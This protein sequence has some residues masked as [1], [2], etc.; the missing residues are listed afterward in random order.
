MQVKIVCVGKLKEKYFV[1]GIKEYSKRI[2]A[3]T[4]FEI[5]EVKDEKDRDNFSPEDINKIKEIEGERILSKIK[6]DDYVITLE[7]KGKQLSSEELSSKMKDLMT[8]GTSSFVF[9][10]GGSHGLSHQVSNRSKLK[11]SFSKMTFP[12]QLMRLILTEQIYRAFKI[13]KNEP[14]HK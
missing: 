3:Y 12:H 11:L 4:K 8:Y 6:Q 14:Y 1:D 5:V 2:G 9:I 10:I 13:M 7:I